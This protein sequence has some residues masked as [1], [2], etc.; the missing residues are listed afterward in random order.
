MDREQDK[1]KGSKGF[2]MTRRVGSVNF[3]II[4]SEVVPKIGQVGVMRSVKVKQ[5]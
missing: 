5:T 3:A 4:P 1:E 2:A